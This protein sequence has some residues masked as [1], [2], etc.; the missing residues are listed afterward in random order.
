MRQCATRLHRV[1]YLL[2]ADSGQ[3]EELTQDALA[4]TYAAWRRIRNDYAYAYARRV[5]VNLHTDWWRARRWRE[6]PGAA[7]PGR[8]ART[9]VARGTAPP[10]P[11]GGALSA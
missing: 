3:A 8:P 5:L 9:D 2:T 11:L 7:G 4:R 6:R 10:R 1:A